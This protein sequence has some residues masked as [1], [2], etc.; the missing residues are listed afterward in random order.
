MTSRTDSDPGP[1]IEVFVSSL[2][3]PAACIPDRQAF[4]DERLSWFDV[5]DELPRY[6]GTSPES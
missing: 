6:S 4:F 2:D 3:D 5:A 1:N